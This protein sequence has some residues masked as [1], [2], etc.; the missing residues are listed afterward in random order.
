MSH[1]SVGILVPSGTE[2]LEGAVSVALAP[3]ESNKWDQWSIGGNWSGAL[4]GNKSVVSSLPRWLECFAILAPGPD[5][6]SRGHVERYSVI[7]DLKARAVWDAE[8]NEV[9]ARYPNHLLVLVDCH[10]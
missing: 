2:D 5:W 7:H 8:R 3:F 6:R 10:I 9:L 4:E 1:Y